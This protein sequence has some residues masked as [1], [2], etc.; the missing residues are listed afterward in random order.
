MSNAKQI[1]AA[2]QLWCSFED[3]D[4]CQCGR[5]VP[6]GT[7]EDHIDAELRAAEPITPVQELAK[8]AVRKLYWDRWAC[9]CGGWEHRDGNYGDTRLTSFGH[10]TP[11]MQWLH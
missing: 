9:I 5:E 8:H 6:K 2:H 7:H 11:H 10:S 1:R 3:Y 4:K